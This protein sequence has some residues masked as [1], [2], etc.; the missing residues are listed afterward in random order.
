MHTALRPSI[1]RSLV[2]SSVYC[3]LPIVYRVTSIYER[4]CNHACVLVSLESRLVAKAANGMLLVHHA[5]NPQTSDQRDGSLCYV[6]FGA[7]RWI[8]IALSRSCLQSTGPV[9]A[10]RH[11]NEIRASGYRGADC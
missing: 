5:A 7:W 8:S 6:Q 1:T 9:L 11:A 4:L 3:G 2:T 10:G